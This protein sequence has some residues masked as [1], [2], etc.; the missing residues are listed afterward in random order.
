MPTEALAPDD[1]VDYSVSAGLAAR[2]AGL[3]LSF[4]FLPTNR[5]SSIWLT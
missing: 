4:P 5:A 2:L 3:G 1:K